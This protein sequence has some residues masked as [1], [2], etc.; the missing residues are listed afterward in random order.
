VDA[1]NQ[2]TDEEYECFSCGQIFRH[3][4]FSISQEWERIDFNGEIPSIEIRDAY[5]LECY[6]SEACAA[7]RRNMLMVNAGVPITRPGIELIELCSKCSAPVDMTEFHLTY[8]ASQEVDLSPMV[9]QTVDM[10]YLA[11]LCRK[12]Q[13]FHSIA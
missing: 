10:D 1:M 13:P 2:L 9:A 5:G 11:I 4:V 7:A 12:C 6:C 3:R 8:I